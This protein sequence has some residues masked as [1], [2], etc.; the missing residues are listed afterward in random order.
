MGLP[1]LFV[2]LIVSGAVLTNIYFTGPLLQMWGTRYIFAWAIDRVAPPWA[3]ALAGARNAPVGAL[4]VMAV[5]TAV[6]GLALIYV[7]NFSLASTSLLQ[8]VVLLLAGLTA[9]V[10]PWRKPELYRGSIKWEFAGIPVI[11]LLGIWAIAYNVVMVY[12]FVTNNSIF[13]TFTS[14]SLWFAGI[15]VLTGLAYYIAAWAVARSHGI[16]VGLAFKEVP[17]E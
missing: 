11:T 14:V 1:N 12:F 15:L 4:A 7:P 6:F 16:D 9:V 5:F 10:F 8:N 2:L 17:P 13:G 3:G